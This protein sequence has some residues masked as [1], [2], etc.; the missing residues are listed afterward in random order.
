MGSI[1]ERYLH[2]RVLD[3]WRRAAQMAADA[4]QAELRRQRES[5]RALQTQLRQVIDTADMRL[6]DPQIGSN[7]FP[8]LIGTDWSWRPDLWR[9]PLATP[10]LASPPRKASLGDQVQVF[11]DC[12]QAEIALRQ[13]R[14]RLPSDLAPFNMGV[15]VFGFEGSFLSLSIQ[16][17]SDASQGLSLQHLIRLDTHIDAEQEIDLFA[18]LNILSGPNTEQVLRKLDLTNPSP[19]VDF[20]LAHLPLNEKRIEKIWL[21]LILENPG[22]NSVTLRDLTLCRHHRADL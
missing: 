8:K 6:R 14:N 12:P 9:W 18:R 16:L 5:A 4:P 21:D 3:R 2:R 7:Q 13:N 10:G 15:E 20:D 11:H 17:P 22:M 1:L 19:S